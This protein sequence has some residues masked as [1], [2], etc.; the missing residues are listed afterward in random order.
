MLILND[1]S[2]DSCVAPICWNSLN[3]A[4]STDEFYHMQVNAVALTCSP[5]IN[6]NNESFVALVVPFLLNRLVEFISMKAISTTW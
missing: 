5:N 1:R 2:F 4:I 6:I 3:E